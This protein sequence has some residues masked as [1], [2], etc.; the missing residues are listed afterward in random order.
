MA[1]ECVCAEYEYLVIP[2]HV[3]LTF[4]QAAWSPSFGCGSSPKLLLTSR[5]TLPTSDP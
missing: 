4:T 5:K 2:G 3:D 1:P